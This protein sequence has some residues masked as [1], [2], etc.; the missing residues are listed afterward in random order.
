MT[1]LARHSTVF[2]GGL[3]TL[4]LLGTA[5]L[6]LVWTPASPTRIQITRRL[7][8]PLEAGLLGA[9]TGREY[10]EHA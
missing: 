1:L 4:L 2:F 9:L 10:R 3:V 8:P 5:L 7:A 6:S